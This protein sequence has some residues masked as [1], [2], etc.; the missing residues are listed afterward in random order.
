MLVYCIYTAEDTVK[1]LSYPGSPIT[2]S[3]LTPSAGTQFEGEPL[4]QG[5]KYTKNLGFLTEIAVYLRNEINENSKFFP[6]CVY[7]APPLTGF[8]WNWVSG[9]V[10][11]NYSDGPLPF[12][13]PADKL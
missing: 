13:I 5:A 6:N 2:L 10:V 12:L 8:P 1:L 11:K 4:Q 3:F 7:F 9:K